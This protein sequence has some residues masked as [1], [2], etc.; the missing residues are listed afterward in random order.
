MRTKCINGTLGIE[1][2]D[3]DLNKVND[4]EKS[5]ILELYN[6]NLVLLFRNQ[7]LKPREQVNFSELFGPVNAHPLKT[8]ASVDGFPQVLILE[9]QP[10]RPGAPNDYWHSDISHAEQ[11]PSATILHSLV[12]P[13]GRGDTM[14]CNMVN[15]YLNLSDNMKA[16]VRNMRALHS[17]IAT[18]ERSIAGASDARTINKAEIKPPQAHPIVRSP[19]GTNQQA[20]FVNPHFTTGIENVCAEE[21][22]WMLNH[23]YRL[24]TQ[25]ENIY[26]HQWQVGDVLV[27]DNRRTMHYAVRDY[28]EDMPRKL[29]RCTA[30]GEIPV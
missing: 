12:V 22:S 19:S 6:Q 4:Q 7:N 8:R 28:T 9:N 17:G 25:P 10:G 16:M 26:R 13:E 29:H 14:L 1:I 2:Y 3:I 23:M 5:D 18:F 27:W 11:P 24:A 21:S 20:I 15:A 30:Q